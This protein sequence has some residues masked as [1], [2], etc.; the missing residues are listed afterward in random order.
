MCVNRLR[1]IKSVTLSAEQS[2]E[3]GQM[4]MVEDEW[5]QLTAD[6]MMIPSHLEVS[7]ITL[8]NTHMMLPSHLEVSKRHVSLRRMCEHV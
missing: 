2:M 5:S 7:E 4:P 6:E 3:S 8:C 1:Y